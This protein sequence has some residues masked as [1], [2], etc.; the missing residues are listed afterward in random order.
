MYTMVVSLF[1]LLEEKS[2]VEPDKVRTLGF[3]Q[4]LGNAD[5]DDTSSSDD[6]EA[7]GF[8]QGVVASTP[9]ASTSK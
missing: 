7:V 2:V 5:P 1:D 4:G 3:S 8:S 9:Q 6:D